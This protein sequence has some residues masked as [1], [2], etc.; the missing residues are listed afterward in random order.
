MV[1]NLDTVDKQTPNPQEQLSAGDTRDWLGFQHIPTVAKELQSL[2][3][4]RDDRKGQLALRHAG[5]AKIRGLG[6]DRI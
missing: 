2:G 1:S 5:C 6:R 3:T 4:L